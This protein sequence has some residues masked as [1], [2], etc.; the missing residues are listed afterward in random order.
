MA[1]LR[2][3]VQ[4]QYTGDHEGLLFV[5]GGDFVPAPLEYD[6]W[7]I[8]SIEG[9]SY[10]SAHHHAGERHF[11]RRNVHDRGLLGQPRLPRV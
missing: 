9:P 3:Y 1:V 2:D 8:E 11:G 10:V 5:E 4:E 7:R 6:D